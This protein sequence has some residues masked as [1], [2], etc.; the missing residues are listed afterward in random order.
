M[1]I[2]TTGSLLCFSQ[3]PEGVVTVANNDTKKIATGVTVTFT[4][5]PGLVYASLGASQGIFDGTLWQVGSLAPGA[6]ATLDACYEVTDECAFPAKITYVVSQGCADDASNNS[7]ERCFDPTTCKDI[8]KCLPEDI[9]TGTP[10]TITDNGDG[11]ATVLQNDDTTLNNIVLGP[12]VSPDDTI[13]IN[14]NATS[15]EWEFT[16]VHTID[17]DLKCVPKVDT[18]DP[19]NPTLCF[20]LVDNVLGTVIQAD[21]VCTP[22]S[23]GSVVNNNDGTVSIT[24]NGVTEIVQT[25]PIVIEG[26]NN[27]TVNYDAATLT[28]TVNGCCTTYDPTTGTLTEVDVDGNVITNVIATA[29]SPGNNITITGTGAPSDPYIVNGCCVTYNTTSGELTI[30]NQNGISNTYQL[31]TNVTSVDNTVTIDN[32]TPGVFDLSVPVSSYTEINNNDGTTSFTIIQD[33]V[34]TTGCYKNCDTGNGQ[35]IDGAHTLTC[36]WTPIFAP[37]TGPDLACT[38]GVTTYEYVSNTVGI[39]VVPTGNGGFMVK[40]VDCSQPIAGTESLTYE[41]FCD[42]VSQ[43]TAD[44]IFTYNVS[45]DLVVGKDF[46]VDY[47][48]TGEA[49]QLT[50]TAF[51]AGPGPLTGVTLTDTLLPNFTYVSDDGGS[52]GSVTSTAPFVWDIGNLAAGAQEVIVIDLTVAAAA[53]FSALP[54]VVLGESNEDDDAFGTDV[55]LETPILEADLAIEKTVGKG[56]ST[57]NA[58]DTITFTLTVTNNGPATSTGFTVEDILDASFIN[59]ASSAPGVTVVGNTVTWNNNIPLPATQ[60][61][62]IQIT[63]EVGVGST[64]TI[65]NTATITNSNE[66]DVDPTN[67]SDNDEVRILES[68]LSIVKT[69]ILPPESRVTATDPNPTTGVS[70]ITVTNTGCGG[71]ATIA[72]GTPARIVVEIRD[73]GTTGAWTVLEEIS[74][75]TGQPVSTY[76]TTGGTD[77]I[78]PHI[79]ATDIIFDCAGGT[80]FQFDKKSW[81]YASGNVYAASGESIQNGNNFISDPLASFAKDIRFTTYVG[82]SGSI[83]C[84]VES[85]N[86]DNNDIV[87][88]MLREQTSQMG[89]QY[90]GSLQGFNLAFSNPVS[91]DPQGDIGLTGSE[92]YTPIVSGLATINVLADAPVINLVEDSG[93]GVDFEIDIVGNSDTYHWTKAEA[94]FPNG[95]YSE[96]YINWYDGGQPAGEQNGRFNT[97]AGGSFNLQNG[98]DDYRVTFRPSISHSFG[99]FNDDIKS[100]AIWEI[101]QLDGGGT[102]SANGTMALPSNANTA[103]A[104]TS[105]ALVNLDH[106]GVGLFNLHTEVTYSSNGVTNL[107]NTPYSLTS[108]SNTQYVIAYWY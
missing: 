2:I 57:A 42:G 70:D 20:D 34:T 46:S 59:V 82:G 60:S 24:I 47:A 53:G 15:G 103:S 32:T 94:T 106:L 25:G 79:P 21:V 33:G 17:T 83:N 66:L 9:V 61:T 23:A 98:C 84:P 95:L 3:T 58:G 55:V 86:T 44:E 69:E 4:T 97:S 50:L 51:N 22:L 11:T 30:V 36:D 101:T 80:T 48:E 54:N 91:L 52:A 1:D 14:Y 108:Y 12:L 107:T 81:A 13:T 78:I 68:N 100:N 62:S 67:D 18:T 7:G 6:T 87:C 38:F 16:T 90:S 26:G 39:E 37:T 41:M 77:S 49:I 74:G 10:S 105:P 56:D 40:P 102:F 29:I 73:A 96:L 92:K 76:T 27:A 93:F 45:G 8:Q 5:P 63:A 75:L 65:P 31:V 99:G 19:L 88:T 89:F 71:A 28:W 43:G 72:C 35:P 85:V 64:G 104:T